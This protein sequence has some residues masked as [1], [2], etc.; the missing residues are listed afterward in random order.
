[1]PRREP[2]N[3]PGRPEVSTVVIISLTAFY[4]HQLHLSQ[5]IRWIALAPATMHGAPATVTR[6]FREGCS[7]LGLGGFR[8]D[9][10]LARC[11]EPLV[12]P[13]L[14]FVPWG[15][16]RRS[17]ACVR[18]RR[19]RP[20]RLPD[21]WHAD[22]CRLV[23]AVSGVECGRRRQ[24]RRS[25]ALARCP[26]QDA[27]RRGHLRQDDCRNSPAAS[28]EGA[29]PRDL[30]AV[31][32]QPRDAR[33]DA[34]L[35]PFGGHRPDLLQCRGIGGIARLH[36]V[37]GGVELRQRAFE[38]FLRLA[39]GSTAQ[40]SCAGCAS[41]A[42]SIT[43]SRAY[44]GPTR[45]P[46]ATSRS[47]RWR[48][49]MSTAAA[50]YR[51]F[52]PSSWASRMP[53]MRIICWATSSTPNLSLAQIHNACLR[54]PMFPRYPQAAS[55]GLRRGNGYGRYLLRPAAAARR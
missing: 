1:M 25:S 52:R 30:G 23:C 53:S 55:M 50:T 13:L 15:L 33:G 29:V 19:R 31:S 17:S 36:A 34:G 9:G 44:S 4:W 35:L 10:H 37:R 47:S 27:A 45:R 48:C 39:S 2:A 14:K 20:A 43:P 24:Y 42:R 22:R 49:S 11:C 46:R 7:H 26:S 16:R 18:P 5:H 41:C 28:G 8:A 32:R 40:A 6:L 21:Q 12:V 38:A 51:A 54:S 3:R